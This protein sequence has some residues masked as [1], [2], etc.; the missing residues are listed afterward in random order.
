[1]A[2]RKTNDIRFVIPTRTAH[3]RS[4][5]SG[6]HLYAVPGCLTNSLKVAIAPREDPTILER[7]G[8]E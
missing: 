3:P 1:V 6:C 7:G 5:G 2:D 8:D 4:S